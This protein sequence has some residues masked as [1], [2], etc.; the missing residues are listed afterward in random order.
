MPLLI[1][2]VSI[3]A[4]TLV[5]YLFNKILPFRVCPICAGVSLT[6]FLISIGIYKGILPAADWI[7]LLT[8]LMGGTVVGIAYQA[9]KTFRWAKEN[10]VLSK[11]LIIL[12][13]LPLAYL[14]IENL[15]LGT[16]LIEAVLM[17][18]LIYFFF[19]KKR[20]SAPSHLNNG[21]TISD[22]EKQLEECC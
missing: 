3:A 12:V 10:N 13:G 14:A 17:I 5:L 21:K 1:V 11:T 18:I 16:I 6:W 8:M 15:A 7:M 4:L 22:L 20:G 2:I 19:I 9:E